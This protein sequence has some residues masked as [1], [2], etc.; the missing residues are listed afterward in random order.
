MH[1]V[2]VVVYFSL[3]HSV[4]IVTLLLEMF[5]L[6]EAWWQKLLILECHVTYPAMDIT[7]GPRR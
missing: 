5:W 6:E 3:N 4:F 2:V 7:L 1:C